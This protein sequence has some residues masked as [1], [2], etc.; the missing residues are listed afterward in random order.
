MQ[1]GMK[2][3]LHEVRRQELVL[4][5][6][7]PGAILPIQGMTAAVRAFWPV[8]MGEA[9][10]ELKAVIF[11]NHETCHDAVEVVLN[12]GGEVEVGTMVNDS[13]EH[14]KLYDYWTPT[15]NHCI[16]HW[17]STQRDGAGERR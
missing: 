4:L 3:E 16:S 1:F 12:V 15:P 11:L 5:V 6:P 13:R 2:I 17:C 14:G 9:P 10:Q 7:M 8:A